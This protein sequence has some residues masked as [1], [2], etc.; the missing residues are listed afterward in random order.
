MYAMVPLKS[1]SPLLSEP[2]EKEDLATTKM[3]NTAA[4][5]GE[6]KKGFQQEYRVSETLL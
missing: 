3:E 1:V 4:V 2:K 6:W 5:L